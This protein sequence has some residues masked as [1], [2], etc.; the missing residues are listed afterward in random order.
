MPVSLSRLSSVLFSLELISLAHIVRILTIDI[1]I[2]CVCGI[3]RRSLRV[4]SLHESLGRSIYRDDFWWRDL[5]KKV[6]PAELKRNT[7][8]PHKVS[9]L[10]STF[11]IVAVLSVTTTT[12][13]RDIIFN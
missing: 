13:T 11:P 2:V 7:Y 10:E 5:P 8:R 1:V 9:T 3:S 6:D 12:T 4:V